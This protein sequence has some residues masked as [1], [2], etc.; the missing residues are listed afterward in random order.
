[1]V[2]SPKLY[3]SEAEYED[4]A[5]SLSRACGLVLYAF[6]QNDCEQKDVIIRQFVAK[7]AMSL[8]G[9]FALWQ[10][11]NYQ[12]SWALHRI[13][14]DRLFH[15]HEI[16]EKNEFSQFDD[17]SFFKRFCGQNKV[18]SDPS[19]KS[20]ATGWEYELSKEQKARVKKLEKNPP[21]WKRPDPE[22]VAKAMQ[23]DFLYKYGYDYASM[24][25]HP[26]SD[27]GQQDFFTITKLEP[28]PKFSSQL[29]VL[30]NSVLVTMLVLQVAIN[31]SSFKWRKVLF[32]YIEDITS[33]LNNGDSSF[34]GSY[35]D[36]F[37][38]AKDNHLCE[39]A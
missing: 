16:S 37:V 28:A 6:A 2:V 32:R 7:S 14:L 33:F 5:E 25:V 17:W 1:M 34:K 15:L 26:M 22:T 12:D 18:K 21:K 3:Q 29:S 35:T 30:H 38:F 24:H 31:I 27:D 36:L 11:E 19:F 4:A 9:V 8:R 10:L 13:L 23:L 39:I 20:Q